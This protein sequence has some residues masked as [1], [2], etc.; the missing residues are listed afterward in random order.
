MVVSK[1]PKAMTLVKKNSNKVGAQTPSRSIPGGPSS[2]SKL[3][4]K[5]P[6]MKKRRFASKGALAL[7]DKYQTIRSGVNGRRSK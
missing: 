1:R 4:I 3:K 5:A 6:E 7:S 2:S